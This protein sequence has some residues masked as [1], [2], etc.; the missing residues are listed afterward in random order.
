MYHFVTRLID[1]E[2]LMK[3]KLKRLLNYLLS[4]LP[5]QLPVGLTEYHKFTDSIIDLVGPIADNDSLKWAISNQIIHL[6]PQQDSVAKR[7][8]VK[9]LRK[10]AANQVASAVFQ[11]IKNKQQEAFA[12]QQQAVATASQDVASDV[13]QTAP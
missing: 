5:S 10:A 12:A 3:Q 6:K 2:Y 9:S 7:Y 11:E 4:F 8:F 1:K 13:N